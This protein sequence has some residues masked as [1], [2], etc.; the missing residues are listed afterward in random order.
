MSENIETY[1]CDECNRDGVICEL[2]TT[3]GAPLYCPMSGDD[4]KD[5][6]WCKIEE[7]ELEKAARKAATTGNR[8]DLRA[9][10]RMR[11]ERL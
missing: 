2:K 7:N 6:E 1:F 10:L 5:G 3:G 4:M 8:K 9:Y 11:K